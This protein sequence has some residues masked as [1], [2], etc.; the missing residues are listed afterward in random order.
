M[1][2]IERGSGPP[3]LLLHGLFDTLGTWDCLIPHLSPVFNVYAVD[4]PG[5]GKTPLPE[6]WDESLSGMVDAVMQFMDEKD[7]ERAAL[8]GNSMGGSLA[9]ALAESAPSRFDKIGLL[10]P[11]GLPEP[12]L[13]MQKAR[14]PVWGRF[15][16]Y[17][18][19]KRVI[20]QCAKSI[21][22][23]SLHNPALLTPELINRVVSPFR[24]VAVRKHLFRFLQAISLKKI[25][26][27]DACLSSITASVLII[28]GKEDRWLSSEHW[29]WLSS[30][31]PDAKVVELPECGH[32]PQLEKPEQVAQFLHPFL[33][34][35]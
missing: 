33:S 8:V 14:H 19:G 23:R 21:Y 26:E 12:P 32:L 6:Q 7:I 1:H 15:L 22:I 34:E 16:P 27:I 31:I 11:Y 10:N 9:L 5:F 4:L 30:R 20:R 29:Q 17:L 2:A 28:W 3:L 25:K 18:L 13:A 35:Q 24:T